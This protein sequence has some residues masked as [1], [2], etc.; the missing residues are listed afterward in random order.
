MKVTVTLL[1][2]ALVVGLAPR[3]GAGQLNLEDV[4]ARSFDLAVALSPVDFKWDRFTGRILTQGSMQGRAR[5]GL[6]VTAPAP[7]QQVRME[8][9]SGVTIRS[10]TAEGAQVS[11]TRSG[12]QVALTF[13][14]GLAPGARVAV[15][16]EYDGQPYYIY[17]EFV[18]LEETDFYPVLVSPFGDY[19]ANLARVTVQVTAPEGFT[20]VSTGRQVSATGN[21]ITWDSEV[22]V[23][24][25]AVAGGRRHRRIDRTVG[26]VKLQMYIGP[27]EERNLDKLATF[28]GQ[29][30]DFYSRLLYACPYTE[31]KVVSLMSV[32]GGIGYPAMLLI[33]DRAFTGTLPGDLNRDSNLF[34][35]MAHETAHSYVPSQTVPKGVGHIWLSEGFAQYLALMATE[36]VMGPKAY[37]RE[38]QDQRDGYAAIAGTS[39]DR[40]VST[41]ARANYT[42]TGNSYRIVYNKGSL[43]LHMLRHV[44]GDQPFR[45]TLATYFQRTRGRAARVEEFREIAEEVSGQ[46]LDW[47]FDEWISQAVVP[48]YSVVSATSTRTDQGEFKTTA[49]IRNS[50]GGVMPVE[51]AFGTGE[52]RVIRRVE[53]PSRG[54]TSV[55]V[56][57]SQAIRQVEVD[58]NKWIIQ[59]NY[60]NDVSE[61]R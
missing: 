55:T 21:T 56:E 2:V 37:E 40:P 50:G 20:V 12:R 23:P 53:V 18:E 17:N 59:S 46:K 22:P 14:Q 10:V 3:P 24:W 31:L 7:I 8:L 36:D 44:I 43:V 51:V 60:K 19:S 5:I 27:N 15:T 28:T 26:S 58:P 61:I 25:V 9:N 6:E 48:D 16:L 1:A 57:T 42:A 30:V 49:T 33:D 29:A 47:F 34:R 35:F 54:D 11:F 39:G 45:K 41:F 4:V 38:L 52:G 32:G 13:P